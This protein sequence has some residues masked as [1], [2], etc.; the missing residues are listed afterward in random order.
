LQ[1]TQQLNIIKEGVILYSGIRYGEI[2]EKRKELTNELVIYLD[3]EILFHLVG[4]N[5]ILYKNLFLDFY[6]LVKELNSVKRK[7]ILKYFKI[8][9]EE[10]NNYFKRAEKLLETPTKVNPSKTAMNNIL[11]G[12][13][14][15][16]D[17]LRKKTEF[18]SMIN[19]YNIHLDTT[20]TYLTKETYKYNIINQELEEKLKE[21]H[22]YSSYWIDD[23]LKKL[24]EIS[25]LRGENYNKSFND[26]RYILLSANSRIFKITYKYLKEPREIPLVTHFD[27]LI[28]KFWLKL[29]KGFGTIESPKIF[30]VITKA[31]IVLSNTIKNNVSEKYNQLQKEIQDGTISKEQ[32]IEITLDL[33]SEVKQPEEIEESLLPSILDSLKVEDIEKHKY[34]QKILKEQ[35]IKNEKENNRLKMDMDSLKKSQQIQQQELLKSKS[36]ELKSLIKLKEI[37]DK[38]SKKKYNRYRIIWSS[39]IILYF[40]IFFIFINRYTWDKMEQWTWILGIAMPLIISYIYTIYSEKK[41]DTLKHFSYK[42]EFYLKDSYKKN[43]VNLDNLSCLENEIE[44]INQTLL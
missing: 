5:G 11:E 20:E 10:I 3:M 29:N 30:N 15:R 37:A 18:F 28:N 43:G 34:E 14:N 39:L 24:N 4:Y 36:K 19:Q 26:I 13:S 12:C 6:N 21:N 33:K 7:V 23:S 31:Q 25:I 35:S 9:E 8:T 16:S 44:K 32:I 27:F 42:K 22:D 40:S 1:F 41:F 2:T 38:E 17:I